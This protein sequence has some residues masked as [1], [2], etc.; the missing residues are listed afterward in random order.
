MSNVL[1]KN[2][3]LSFVYLNE[4]KKMDDG[5]KRCSVCAAMSK[6]EFKKQKAAIEAAVKDAID[7]GVKKGHFKRALTKTDSFNLPWYDAD[8]KMETGEHAERPELKGTI[9]FNPWNKKKVPVVGPDKQPIHDPD[10]IYSGMWAHVHVSLFPYGTGRPKKG[11]GAWLNAVMKIRDDVPLDGTVSA[12][13]AFK[14][15]EIMEDE[16]LE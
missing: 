12:E 3:R 11:V 5:S 4:H 9:C 6:M 13:E 8:Q 10:E 1:L 2:C 15:I 14:E 16:D 7:V